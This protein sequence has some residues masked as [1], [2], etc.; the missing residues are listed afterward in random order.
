MDNSQEIVERLA[1]I[2]TKIDDYATMRD[3]AEKAYALAMH[4]HEDIQEIKDNNKWL[5][6]TIVGMVIAIFVGLALANLR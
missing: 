3:K 6:R 4:N 2:E 1:R 5:W